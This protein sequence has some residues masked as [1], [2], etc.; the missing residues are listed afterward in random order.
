MAEARRV[1]AM[2]K[3][4]FPDMTVSVYGLD[5]WATIEIARK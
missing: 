3:A 2:V 4:Q 5:E 1:G